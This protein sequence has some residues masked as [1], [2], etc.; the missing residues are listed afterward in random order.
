MRN[1]A[2]SL[3]PIFLI[4]A[5]LLRA[6]CFAQDSST[7]DSHHDMDMPGMSSMTPD[8]MDMQPHSLIAAMEQ[9]AISGTDVEPNS[10][11]FEM[12]MRKEGRWTLMFHGEVFVNEAQQTGPRGADKFF[13]TN[14]FMPMAQREFGKGT[15]TLRTMLSLEPATISHRRYPE[16]FQQGEIA[17][18]RPIVDGQHPHDFFMELAALYDYKLGENTALSFY[19]APVGDPAFGPPAFPH[20][21][22][23][24]EDPMA[25]LG[26]HFQDSTHI[27]NEV[28]TVGITHR[29]FR[30]EASGFHG[31]EPDEYRWDIDSGKIDSWSTRVTVNPRQNWSL[32][33]SLAQLHSP[34]ALLPNED[35]RRM[36]ASLIYNRPMHNGNWASM[37]LWGRNQSLQDGNVGNSYL[38][39]STLRFHG[40]HHAWIRIENADRTNELPLGENPLPP[41]FS[42]RYFTRVQGYTLGYD[43]EL[44]H[45]QHLSTAVGGQVMWYGV[46]STLKLEYGFHPV[47][48]VIFLRAGIK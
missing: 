21:A 39:E 44:G 29:S 9:H 15:L 30:L 33:Y 47:G 42:E 13:S 17:Y 4:I 32:Q 48:V 16:L 3:M 12:F 43:R 38:L 37:I 2:V 7:Q 10:T 8:N 41:S 20:R 46:P 6:S 1:F 26:H 45:L 22:S 25:P 40:R 19:A 14:W 24:S 34:E 28:I 5:V 18:G 35:L 31:R 27:A 36:T 23:A 11:P